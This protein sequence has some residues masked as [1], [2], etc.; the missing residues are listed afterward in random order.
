MRAPAKYGNIKTPVGDLTFDSAKEARRYGELTLL[1]RAGQISDLRRQIPY[2][3]IVNG[4][5]VAKL[6]AD[7]DYQEAGE[8]VVE[9]VKSPFTRKLPVWRLKSKMF[10][11]Q[12]GFPVREV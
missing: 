2:P 9:D 6:V 4:V 7:F 5:K 1:Q 11:A 3:L 12:Y 10:A 8:L